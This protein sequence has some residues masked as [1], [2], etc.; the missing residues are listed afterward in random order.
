MTD[1]HRECCH[2][3]VFKC[4]AETHWALDQQYGFISMKN[5]GFV[6]FFS[7]FCYLIAK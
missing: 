4:S 3:L 5:G 2:V 6:T 1:V 7:H